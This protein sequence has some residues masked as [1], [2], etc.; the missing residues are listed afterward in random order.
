M[1][2]QAFWLAVNAAS[3]MFEAQ[4]VEGTFESWMSQLWPEYEKMCTQVAQH[5]YVMH[6]AYRQYQDEA[7][8]TFVDTVERERLVTLCQQVGL[9][10]REFVTSAFTRHKN[11][12]LK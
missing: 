10:P 6:T 3:D 4:P 2:S 1:Q 7:P 11:A 12:C 8:R 5:Y 9:D